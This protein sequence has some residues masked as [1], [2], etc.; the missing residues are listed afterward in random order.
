MDV[1]LE[2]YDKIIDKDLTIPHM[3]LYARSAQFAPFAALS[4]YDD[5]IVEETRETDTLVELE[6]W[7]MEQLNQKL[8][9]VADVLE[10]GNKPRLTFTLFVPDEKKAVSKYVD[11]TDTVKCIDTT[12]RKVILMSEKDAVGYKTTNRTRP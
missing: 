9:L 3:S 1:M 12:T 5:M 10:D 6:S 7:E 11:I 8:K 2:L 4:G